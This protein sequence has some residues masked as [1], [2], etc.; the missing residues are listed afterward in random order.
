MNLNSLEKLSST[1]EQ[2]DINIKDTLKSK[3]NNVKNNINGLIDKAKIYKPNLPN[4]N[5]KKLT[6]SDN[7]KEKIDKKST[8]LLAKQ[9]DKTIQGNNLNFNTIGS[10]IKSFASLYRNVQKYRRRVMIVIFVVG[11]IIACFVFYQLY[12]YFKNYNVKPQI[13]NTIAIE[14]NIKNNIVS[15][16][17][18]FK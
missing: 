4:I 1:F 18:E 11:F 15:I 3:T 2:K 6:F 10:S 17:D 14:N 9:I 12:K 13:Q 7:I 16:L 8:D 5:E